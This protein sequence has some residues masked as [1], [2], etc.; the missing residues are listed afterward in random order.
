[1]KERWHRWAVGG[2]AAGLLAVPFTARA[3]ESPPNG[4]LTEQVD[5]LRE[6]VYELTKQLRQLE[7]QLED[8]KKAAEDKAKKLP[9]VG[10]GADGFSI[11]SADKAFQLKIGGRILYDVGFFRQDSELEN[12][13]GD[14]Q[15]GTG[16]RAARIRLQGKLWENIQFQAEYDFAGES[17]EDTPKFQDVF[18]QYNNIPYGGGRGFDFRVGHFREPFGLEELTPI[19]YRTFVERSLSNVFVPGRN[20]GI[21][22][23]DALFGEPKQE[24]L[25]YQ[26]GVF[27]ETDDWPSSNDSDEDRGYIITGRVTGLPYYQDEGRKLVHVGLAYSHRNP[28][29]ARVNYGLRPESRL[30]LFRTIDPDRL[31]VGFRLRDARADDVDLFGGELAGVWGPFS[32]QAEY[33]HSSV[34]TTFGGNVDVGGY[35]VQAS[36]FLTGEHRPYRNDRGIFDRVKPNRNFGFK[37]ADGYG[38]WEIAARY[39]NVDLNDGPIRGGEHQ[40]YTLGVNWYLNPNTEV[41]LNYVHNV[42][43][44]DLYDGDFDFLQARF[45]LEF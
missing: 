9:V 22:V 44:H 39:S 36:Y 15:D 31:P 34:D 32:V 8:D 2:L 37:A 17:G 23:S 28:D 30:A 18:V 25:T 19:P 1:M 26:L 4:A 21:Q 6:Q 16:F 27:K 45:T 10:A 14:E 12:V 5:A 24:R 33:V 40:S 3:D 42:V 43:E 38:A 35:Y 13:V 11:T 20:A 7:V 29:G 41:Q